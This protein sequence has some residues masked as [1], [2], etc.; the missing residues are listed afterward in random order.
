[1]TD[2]TD[3]LEAALIEM[4]VAE[5]TYG[6]PIE[7]ETDLLLSEL[8]DSLGVVRIVTWLEERLETEIDPT[9][10]VI[11]NFQSVAQMVRYI[12]ER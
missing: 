10:V 11:E 3:S 4:I 8:V 7:V 9:D 5:I 1:V 2:P 12:N 6:Q